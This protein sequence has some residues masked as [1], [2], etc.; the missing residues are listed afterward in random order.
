M[1]RSIVFFD[2][3]FGKADKRLYE[4]GA[5]CTDGSTYHGANIR[6]FQHYLEKADI[7]CGHNILAH[8]IELLKPLFQRRFF[9]IFPSNYEF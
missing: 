7:L 1:D 6:E 3:E 4:A 8:D 9:R 5:V 2:C